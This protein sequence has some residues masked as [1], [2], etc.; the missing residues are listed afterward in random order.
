MPPAAE[1]PLEAEPVT[2][3]GPVWVPPLW[4]QRE[5]PCISAPGGSLAAGPVGSSRSEYVSRDTF[6]SA[7]S[8]F[9]K[10]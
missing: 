10:N 3:C 4:G 7:V 1:A 8:S 9:G 6:P 2:R 5:V